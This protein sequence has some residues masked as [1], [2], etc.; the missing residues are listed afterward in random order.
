[1]AL[2]LD[3]TI[4]QYSLHIW[5]M[6]SG[7]PGNSIYA[8]QQTQDG[9][10]WIG[11]GDGL[12]RFDGLQFELYN[13]E[14]IEE[15]KSNEVRALYED[16]HGTLW[17]GT[18]S[19][20][21]TCYQDGKFV[22][23]PITKY[24]TL[25]SIRAIH[26][27]RWGNL[28]V[29]SFTEGLTC[30][31]RLSSGKLQI[32]TYSK[33]QGLPG[34]QVKFIYK[35]K[36]GD[37]WVTTSAGIVKLLEP[38]IFQNYASRE[39]LPYLKTVCLY[40]EDSKELLIG[41]FG[42]GLFRA[43]NVS[44]N[45]YEIVNGVPHPNINYLYRDRMKNLWIGTEG[46]GLTLIRNG[47]LSTLA[48]GENLAW[49]FVYCI[50]EDREGSIWIGTLDGGLLQLI[51][52]KFTTYT[53]REGLSHD[54]IN[55]IYEDRTGSL[56]IGTQGGLNRLG[57]KNGELTTV[58][59]TSS[60]LLNDEISWIF[61]DPVDYFWIGTYGGL[62]IFK[63]GKLTTLTKKHGLSDN[64]IRCIFED[65]Q[66]NT[67]IGTE[68]G[69][70]RFNINNKKF[71]LFT[72][73][74]GLSSNY[75]EVIYEDSKGHLWIGTD[76]G[77]NRFSDGKISIYNPK[78][79]FGKNYIRCI[80]EDNKG[81]L[82]FGTF[83]G[84][85]CLRD[86]ETCRYTSQSGLNENRVYSILEDENG[87]LWLGGRNGIS[88]VKKEG[89]E[90]LSRGKIRQIQPESYNEKDGMK[91][92]WCTNIGCKT[93]D[94]RLWF[95]TSV[96]VTM[97]DPNHIRTNQLSLP[98]KIEKIIV[99]GQSIYIHEKEPGK[100]PIKLAPG[101]KRLEFYYTSVS[102]INP[103]KIKFKIRMIGYDSDWIDMGNLR[104]TTY[105]GLP[106][107]EYTFNVIA[108]NPDGIWNREGDSFSLYLLP[109]FYQTTWFYFLAGFSVLF[110]GF[111]V[112]CLRV[113]QLKTREKELT[114]LVEA[115][116]RDLKARTN[117][118]ENAHIK[119]RQSK[120]IIEEKNRH[121]MDSFR[122]AHKIQQTMLPIKEKLEKELKDHFVIY[123][124]KD[125][126]SG[127]F[128]WFDVIEDQYFLAVADC[129]GH[130][131][132][133]ALL[134]MIGCMMLNEVINERQI[135]DPAEILGR[136]HQG[137]RYILKQEKEKTD[138]YDGMDI[139][140]CRVDL[141][142]GKITY[143][144]ARRSLFYAANS[145]FT[146]IKGD[147]KSIGGRQKEKKHFFT[148]HEINISG[149]DQDRI[150]IY[151]TTDGFADQ[152]NPRNQKYGSHQLKQFLQSIAALPVVQ[153]EE[154][155][156]EEL[157]KHQANEEQRDD[158]TII[159]IRLK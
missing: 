143:A 54:F 38:G 98:V 72:K 24:K 116:T 60:G 82:W 102:F 64:R 61:E 34:N 157:D 129:T 74:E 32:K 36:N 62:H 137:F 17:I 124:P 28:W 63:D 104:S 117:E 147:R 142:K 150:M 55:F 35:D 90:D 4:T 134:S 111:L 141:Q 128:Y 140:L 103:E 135:L 19:G 85:I 109:Y 39:V 153:Q 123:K 52:N 20:G 156:L 66:G 125:I 152:H 91:S 45:A 155:L 10:I 146:E 30:I 95:P 149:K 42:G 94:G 53:T 70:N 113:R 16:R 71:T 127:D 48:G 92:R 13:K 99:D 25:H 93:R 108:C 15:L 9:Y 43:K 77:L 73:K 29:G 31:R 59:T 23:Y 76:V 14:K 151:L 79:M 37:L 33:D 97:I 6:E 57:L 131:V 41:T 87:Y 159:G 80:Y 107:G 136:L 89:L 81:V 120:E 68:N 3:K 67:W 126:V 121:I 5:N 78:G 154:A 119:L 18:S 49:G 158:I 22:T 138:T 114:Q 105:T 12:V 1:M 21:L 122:Y 96:G 86:N 27:D 133:G 69:L 40:K 58:L 50:Y 139:G 101:K 11:T 75:I 8:V 112:Y 26:E 110:F 106:P 51:D 148:N 7:L 144:G 88:R 65:K 46:E 56:W 84:L 47:K 2:D 115:R 83:D 130:G 118:L 145:E 44:L 132:P 100:T